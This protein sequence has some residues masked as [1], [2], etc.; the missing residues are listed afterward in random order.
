MPVYRITG[1]VTRTHDFTMD[2]EASDEDTACEIAHDEAWYHRIVNELDPHDVE[3]YDAVEV[4]P[5]EHEDQPL[6]MRGGIA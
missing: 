4:E 6:H 2:V 1:C 3:I 5:N